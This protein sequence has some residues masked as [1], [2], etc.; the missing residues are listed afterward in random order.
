M[1]AA[2]ALAACAAAPAQ[3]P[4][5]VDVRFPSGL[6]AEPADGRLLLI[7]STDDTREPRFQVSGTIDSAQVFGIDVEGMAPGQ[8]V[9]FD[10]S[11]FGYPLERMYSLP[12][13]TYTVQAVLHLYETF[14]VA[15]VHRQLQRVTV[16]HSCT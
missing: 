2:L 12:R 16:R 7:F 15:P 1:I 6:R 4:A 3:T 8:T 5:Y 11:V 13:R 9:R 10:S 14:Q